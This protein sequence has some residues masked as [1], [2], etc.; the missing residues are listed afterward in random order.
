[1]EQKEYQKLFADYCNG[2]TSAQE[3]KLLEDF[4]ELE[5][6][7]IQVWDEERMGNKE[8]VRERIAGQLRLKITPP[9][10]QHFIFPSTF[11]S[12]AA[13][14]LLLL[15]FSYFFFA[16]SLTPQQP[17][18]KAELAWITKTTP[19][20]Q[21]S[22]ILLEDSTKVYL[23]AESTLQFPPRFE[24]G[25]RKVI[26]QGEAY[27]EVKP[28]SS[29]PF[30]VQSGLLNTT[31]LGTSF[32]VAAYPHERQAVTVAEGKVLVQATAPQEKEHKNELILYP[33]EQTFWNP[34]AQQLEKV[35]VQ[36]AD[37]TAWT[38]GAIFL[39]DTPLLELAHILERRYGATIHFENER[40]RQCRISGTIKRMPLQDVL[41]VVASTLPVTYTM[42]GNNV[43]LSGKGCAAL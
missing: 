28:D 26:L 5:S 21:S 35:K 40:V 20:G 39:E 6:E 38:Q 1:M 29:S 10:K 16:N 12:V 8:A 33:N 22:I 9:Q 27:F 11:I 42:H 31:V 23:N 4:Y 18:P 32:N 2:R 19:R 3:E 15:G 14:V 34:D 43:T 25:I 17:Q 41:D 37:V 36:A 24:G 13:S 7:R 30:V